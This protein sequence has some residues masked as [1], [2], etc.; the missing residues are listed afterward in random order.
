MK[1]ITLLTCFAILSLSSCKKD[2][3]CECTDDNPLGSQVTQNRITN[4]TSNHAE[5]I[6]ND[7]DETGGSSSSCNLVGFK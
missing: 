3:V 5:K 1:K 4:E 6:C 7:I 2:W